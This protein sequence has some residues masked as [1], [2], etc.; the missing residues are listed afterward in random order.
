MAKYVVD[1]SV[2]LKWFM[3]ELLEDEAEKLLNADHELL[4]PDLFYIEIT[5]I[6]WKRIRFDEMHEK[7]GQNILE[8]LDTFNLQ[9]FQAKSLC[10]SA[11]E[12]AVLTNC[13][14]YDCL[15]LALAVQEN[16]LFVTADSRF[17][18]S[19]RITPLTQYVVYLGEL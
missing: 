15:Y 8:A 13:T 16:A 9:T 1:A 18:N 11:L 2:G 12:L 7:V 19:I 6:V 17:C 3:P 5:N 10:K 4:V 14:A